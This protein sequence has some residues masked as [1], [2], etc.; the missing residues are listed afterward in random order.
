MLAQEP[1]TSITIL[2]V[3]FPHLHYNV[4]ELGC[5]AISGNFAVSARNCPPKRAIGHCYQP[6]PGQGP[7][8]RSAQ[9]P[10]IC[11]TAFSEISLI[12]D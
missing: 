1:E 10:Y 4:F 8:T 12:L 9:V 3:N 5:E 7:L 6:P 2:T 11:V